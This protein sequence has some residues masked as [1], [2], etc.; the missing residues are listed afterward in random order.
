[1]AEFCENCGK[2]MEKWEATHCS[3]ECLLISM[4]Y[5][6]SVSSDMRIDRRIRMMRSNRVYDIHLLDDLR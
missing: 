5:S 2:S 1:M 3:E 6:K 4:K